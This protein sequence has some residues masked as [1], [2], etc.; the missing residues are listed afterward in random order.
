MDL[1]YIIVTDLLLRN[2]ETDTY[3]FCKKINDNYYQLPGGHLTLKSGIFDSIIFYAKNQLDIN[4]E[5]QNLC[6]KHIMEYP[7]KNK[8]YI[9]IEALY[10][11]EKIDLTKT[12]YYSEYKWLKNDN[13]LLIDDKLKQVMKNIKDKNLY[14]IYKGGF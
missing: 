6:I 7:K 12:S 2:K 14:S 1:N 5:K 10:K 9:S 8:I 11:D 4:L 13:S 3:L